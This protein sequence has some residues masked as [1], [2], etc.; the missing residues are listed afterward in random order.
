VN[1]SKVAIGLALGAFLLGTG[2]FMAGFRPQPLQ[3]AI[4]L[5]SGVTFPGSE[6]AKGC[7]NEVLVGSDADYVVDVNWFPRG[8]GGLVYRSDEAILM[9][10]EEK[11]DPDSAR[12]ARQICRV[13]EKDFPRWVN[14]QRV[15]ASIGKPARTG[16][17]TSVDDDPPRR[18]EMMEY[19][20]GPIVGQALLDTKLGRLWTLTNIVNSAGKTERTEFKEISV[21]NL[22][23]SE[24]EA[25]ADLA[26]WRVK[27]LTR[28]TAIQRAEDQAEKEP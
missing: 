24:D 18:Y 14:T 4:S 17:T 3:A 9:E 16:S 13:I 28:P 1:F 8:W 22:W 27:K 25:S 7:P 12:V 20:N 6:F 23:K 10:F 19:R 5:G 26:L 2:Y 11:P 15:R 21:E